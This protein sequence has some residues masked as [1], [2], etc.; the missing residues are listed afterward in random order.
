MFYTSNVHLTHL[1]SYFQFTGLKAPWLAIDD[2]LK[3]LS[4]SKTENDILDKSLVV[5]E[6]ELAKVPP[7]DSFDH[8]T[9][10]FPE[11][12]SCPEPFKGQRREGDKLFEKVKS[13]IDDPKTAINF[14]SVECL[15]LVP[16]FNSLYVQTGF[17][18]YGQFIFIIFLLLFLVFFKRT[19]FI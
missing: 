7:L 12:I 8:D 6:T 17:F 15:I 4:K 10:T 9:D 16:P 2:K 19:T 5:P 11:H 14:L 1:I 3:T 18:L 13:I